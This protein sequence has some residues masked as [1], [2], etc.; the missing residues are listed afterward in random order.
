[1]KFMQFVTFLFAFLTF[2]ACG[3]TKQNTSISNTSTETSQV[4]IP[5][6][7]SNPEDLEVAT[8][9]AGCFW[10]MDAAYQQLYGVTKVEVG[11]GG[12]HTKNPTY[13]QVCT[14]TT[15]HAECVQVTFDRTKVT[16]AEILDVFWNMHD[17][18]ILNREGND[19]GDDYRSTV[20]YYNEEQRATAERVKQ[21]IDA[22]KIQSKPVVTTIE[23]FRNYYK[24][25]DYHQNYYNL[26]KSEPYCAHVVAK[27]VDHFE[28]KYKAKL[29]KNYQPKMVAGGKIE[30]IVKTEAEWRKQL[31]P[32]QFHILREQGTEPPFKNAYW[33]HHEEG[34]Y[35]CAGCGLPL[36]SSATK[37][38]SGTGWPSFYQPIAKENVGSHDDTSAGMNRTEVSCARCDGH[39]G[40]VFDDG[41]KPTGLRYCI[42]SESLKF[43][44]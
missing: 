24:A 35:N 11:F 34:T 14:R 40:H 13:E 23:A 28:E 44:K 33:N 22:Q 25:E 19:V 8:L 7:P 27:K 16:Y 15:G 26:H 3:T 38:D 37:F 6:A 43:E 39:L 1:M 5:E 29:K 31:T 21:E 2:A 32:Y 20:F 42:D 36:F 30:K 41:P 10:K 17:A 12:G 18:T 4:T 9:A